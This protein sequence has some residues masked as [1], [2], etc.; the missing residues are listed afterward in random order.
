MDTMERLKWSGVPWEEV[1]SAQV[2]RTVSR[3]RARLNLLR[4]VFSYNRRYIRT[5][6]GPFVR[7]SRLTV[8][9]IENPLGYVLSVSLTSYIISNMPSHSES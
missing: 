8:D 4:Q 1:F 7:N 9:D 3:F 5:F 2:S 6:G